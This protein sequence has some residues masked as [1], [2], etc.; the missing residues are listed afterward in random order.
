MMSFLLV[1]YPKASQT[2]LRLLSPEC[3]LGED[4]DCALRRSVTTNF[5]SLISYELC[6]P[7]N[8]FRA[9]RTWQIKQQRQPQRKGEY[10]LNFDK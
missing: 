4:H 2:T 5:R 3:W 7:V 1:A 10:I 6:T 9:G 8:S